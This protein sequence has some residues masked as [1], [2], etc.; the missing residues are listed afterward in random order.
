MEYIASDSLITKM[1]FCTE[2][3]KYNDSDGMLQEFPLKT[4]DININRHIPG[5]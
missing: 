4:Q 5:T 2:A 3:V 1:N